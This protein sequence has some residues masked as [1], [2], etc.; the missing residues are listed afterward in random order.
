MADL[1]LF[2]V[3]PNRL[4]RDGLRRLLEERGCRIVA[5]ASSL[6]GAV[7]QAVA[8]EVP[9]ALVFDFADDEDCRTSVERLR[10]TLPGTRV[11]VLASVAT[12]RRIGQAISWSVDSYLLKDMSAEALVRALELVALGHQIF[13]TRLIMETRHGTPAAGTGFWQPSGLSP[14]EHNLLRAL[15]NGKSNKAIARDLGMSEAVVK[16]QLKTLLRKVRVNNRTQAAVWA[17]NHG[18]ERRA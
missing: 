4:F 16:V 11:V 8:G 18:L 15:V 13:P 9:D 10:F 7:E 12:R 3:D 14:R 17:F 1:R 6:D 5:E 2:L